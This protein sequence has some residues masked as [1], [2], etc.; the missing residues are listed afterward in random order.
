MTTTPKDSYQETENWIDR[1]FDTGPFHPGELEEAY[2]QHYATSN[3]YI[4][5]L[6]NRLQLIQQRFER[7]CRDG[8]ELGGF[9][10][11]P[12]NY[13]EA[14]RLLFDSLSEAIKDK[15]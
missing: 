6:E 1:I 13:P 15:P 4:E 5:Q 11:L 7:Y 10:H 3:D 12:L 8:L 14:Q 9:N 2:E